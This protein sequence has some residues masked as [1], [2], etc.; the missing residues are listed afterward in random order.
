MVKYW[1]KV[2]DIKIK[3][4]FQ[5]NIPKIIIY[6]LESLT[7]VDEHKYLKSCNYLK[8]WINEKKYEGKLVEDKNYFKYDVFYVISEKGFFHGV[9][10][11]KSIYYL[12]SDIFKFIFSINHSYL[13]I[14][15]KKNELN[16]IDFRRI[17]YKYK[18]D[19]VVLFKNL[20]LITN[21][22]RI[23][24][25]KGIIIK[26]RK[27]NTNDPFLNEVI[28]LLQKTSLDNQS[29]EKYDK[30][31]SYERINKIINEDSGSKKDFL[32][33]KYLQEWSN[34]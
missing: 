31:F 25:Y 30:V 29:L 19:N 21:A 28:K 34:M 8:A 5:H 23:I 6:V 32:Y 27:L 12:N 16:Y 33:L 2:N 4:K 22:P 20:G 7:Y 24:K 10:S 26:N 17:L 13:E 18:L 1:S 3:Q 14:T 11:E 9:D 15:C